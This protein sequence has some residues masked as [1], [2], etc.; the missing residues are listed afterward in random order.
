MKARKGA[1]PVPAQTQMMG[2]SSGLGGR[3]K[4]GGEGRTETARRSPVER[5]ER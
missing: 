4:A 2:V 5:V 3:Q 1:R